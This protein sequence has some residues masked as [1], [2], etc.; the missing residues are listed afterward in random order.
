MNKIVLILF[1]N[2]LKHGLFLSLIHYQCTR[3]DL[4]GENAVSLSANHLQ[5]LRLSFQLTTP[6]GHAFKP[7]Q[8]CGSLYLLH[9]LTSLCSVYLEVCWAAG[10][11]Q[12]DTWDQG[13]TY[14]CGWEL[15]QKIWDNT[16]KY[17]SFCHAN[18]FM[19]SF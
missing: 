14:I 16:S 4:A 13:W 2:V 5:K 17:L 6:L 9:E 3:L 12:I 1:W 10:V 11:S 18:L 7:H 15:W 19:A 8:V